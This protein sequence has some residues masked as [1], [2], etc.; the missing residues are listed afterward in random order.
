MGVVVARDAALVVMAKK[1]TARWCL[2]DAVAR[3]PTRQ[4]ER[5]I[6]RLGILSTADSKCRDCLTYLLE[7]FTY[8]RPLAGLPNY[9]FA[10]LPSIVLVMI[11]LYAPARPHYPA[12]TVNAPPKKMRA[13]NINCNWLGSFFISNPHR[14]PDLWDGMELNLPSLGHCRSDAHIPRLPTPPGTGERPR[15]NQ[16][17]MRAFET[18]RMSH[19]LVREDACMRVSGIVCNPSISGQ[20]MFASPPH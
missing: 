14:H 16:A 10:C 9:P 20:R 18:R 1:C 7:N 11:H 17:S 4:V 6:P 8:C 19:E 2:A 13:A 3:F 15:N 5:R 12:L